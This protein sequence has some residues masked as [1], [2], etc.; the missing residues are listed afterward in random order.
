MKK[1]RV[2]KAAP[3]RSEPVPSATILIDGDIP[4][5]P[6]L[7]ETEEQFYKQ[8]EKLAEALYGSLPQA[9]LERLTILLME[10]HV[11]SYW[12]RMKR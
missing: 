7:K 5:R 8:A 4:F 6:G 1:V 11:S 9:T 3:L 2:A 12:G 10:K